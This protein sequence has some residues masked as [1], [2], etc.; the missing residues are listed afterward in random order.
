MAQGGSEIFDRRAVRRNRDR[1]ARMVGQVADV[2]GEMAERLL[3]RLN[4]TT[5]RFT[6]ALDLGGR[7]SVAPL[8]RARG[9]A[10][11]SADLSPAMA[12]LNPA[13]VL[14]ADAEFL[15]FAPASF[16]LAIASLSLHWINDLPG[17]LIQIRRALRPDGL[18]LASLPVL[19]TLAELR[20]ALSEAEAALLGG[21]APRVSPFPDLRDCASLLQRA[22]FALPVADVEELRLMYADPLALLRDLRAAGE[23]NALVQRDRRIPP[24]ALFPAALATLPAEDGRIPVTLRVAVMTGWAPA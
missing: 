5:R 2:L 17:A 19:G 15:P 12:A 1:A 6:R 3:D 13:P 20:A 11:V 7:G 9:I 22:G 10:T 14:A 16:D 21:A 8:L 18:F 4:D 23:A 24:R